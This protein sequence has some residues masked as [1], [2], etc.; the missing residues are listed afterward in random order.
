VVRHKACRGE[1]PVPLPEKIEILVLL[2]EDRDEETRNCALHTLESWPLK[3]LQQVVSDS[4]TPVAVLEFAAYNLAPGRKELRGAL[5]QNQSLSPPVREWIE[6]IAALFAEA[7]AGEFSEA[8]LPILADDESASPEKEP[9][10]KTTVLQ[11][12]QQMSAVQR[13]KAALIGSQEERLILI[14]DPNKTVS[15]AVLQSPKLSER[16]VENFASM[17]DV[18]EDILRTIARSR[19]FA[20][21]YSVVRTLVNNPRTPIDLGLPLL[22]HINEHDL[23]SLALNRNVSDVI[24]TTADK[25]LKRKKH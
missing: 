13:I 19:K 25:F 6:T 16:E 8:P 24:R 12:I 14:R 23:K 20:K 2:A 22:N 11:K 10:K 1:L 15:R 4:S 21:N 18:S 7:E 17:K 3:E 5:L 9:P